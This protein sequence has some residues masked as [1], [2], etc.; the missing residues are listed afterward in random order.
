MENKIKAYEKYKNKTSI[1]KQYQYSNREKNY[2]KR[3]SAPSKYLFW[4]SLHTM[5]HENE[6]RQ[7]QVLKMF[8]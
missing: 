1:E 6:M 8:K 5:F 2:M 7:M 4:E 3:H